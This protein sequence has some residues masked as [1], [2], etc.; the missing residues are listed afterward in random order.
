[1]ALLGGETH[2]VSFWAKRSGLVQ[3]TSFAQVVNQGD[4]TMEKA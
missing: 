3:F 1:M 4:E 2:K